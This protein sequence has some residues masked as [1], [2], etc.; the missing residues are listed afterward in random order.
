MSD[1]VSAGVHLASLT[2]GTSWVRPVGGIF[3]CESMFHPSIDWDTELQKRV[4]CGTTCK[5]VQE[6]GLRADLA[7]CCC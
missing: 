3:S 7:N 4:A 5:G 2:S 1:Q 6:F